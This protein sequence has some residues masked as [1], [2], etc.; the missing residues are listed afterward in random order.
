[1]VNLNNG[2]LVFGFVQPPNDSA[3]DISG[4]GTDDF[5]NADNEMAPHIICSALSL[6]APSAPWRSAPQVHAINFQLNT[7]PMLAMNFA[8]S[9]FRQLV[10]PPCFTFGRERM[11]R[12]QLM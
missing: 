5:Q 8:L 3:P 12:A 2:I 6:S 10:Y 11:V 4:C 9:S 1:V 7:E